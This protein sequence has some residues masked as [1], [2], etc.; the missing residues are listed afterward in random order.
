MENKG[1]DDQFFNCSQEHEVNYVASRYKDSEKV[2]VFLK[3]GCAS[4]KI[5]YM[6]H[7]E[8]YELIEKELGF[9]VPLE[10]H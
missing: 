2:K 6:K 9:K 1:K 3:E 5:K 10:N 4:G 8:L 7:I